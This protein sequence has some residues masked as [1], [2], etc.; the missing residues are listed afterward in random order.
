MSF[1]R[2]PTSGIPSF[3]QRLGYE[4]HIHNQIE[5]CRKAFNMGD[6]T[7]VMYAVQSL[8]ALITP[9]LSDEIFLEKMDKLDDSWKQERRDL[10]A[11]YQRDLADSADGCPDLVDAPPSEPGIDFF[12]RQYMAALALFERKNLALKL[13]KEEDI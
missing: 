3:S 6:R 4:D 5:T 9:K 13:D 1:G 2:P 11:R 7:E 10:S 8:L 12:R